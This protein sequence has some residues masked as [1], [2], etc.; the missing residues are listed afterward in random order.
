MKK[1][2]VVISGMPCVGKT[3]A[4]DVIA[5]RFGLVHLAGGDMLK[6]MAIERGY[7]PSGSDWW[8]KEEGMTFL[9]ERRSNPEFDREVDKRLTS[10][11]KSGG[12][13]VT[14]YTV[15][16]LCKQGLKLWFDASPDTRAS[17][18]AGRDAI[19]KTRARKIIRQRDERNRRLY[20]RIYKID[21]GKDLSVFNYII[22]TEEMTKKQVAETAANLVKT[23]HD[24]KQS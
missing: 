5:K 16:W 2:S 21:F 22:D 11:V 14:S 24:A 8:D 10:K 4:A 3:T 17:R 18:L 20:K 1:I 23:Y 7:T 19:S 15:P 13:V 6:E 9:S 12:V